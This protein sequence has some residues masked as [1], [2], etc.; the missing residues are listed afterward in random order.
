MD[1]AK[2]ATMRAPASGGNGI[3]RGVFFDWTD[4]ELTLQPRP[5][6]FPVL[7][8][9]T[10]GI[11]L[12]ASF[13]VVGVWDPAARKV[14]T[15]SNGLSGKMTPSFVAFKESERLVGAD[16]MCAITP[17]EENVFYDMK[18]LIGRKFTDPT[19]Q[20]NLERWPFQVLEG[21]QGSPV[22]EATFKG[23]TK[24]F[25]PEH[26][27]AM[28][29]SEMKDIAETRLGCK[30]KN[31]VITVP[32]SFNYLQRQCTKEAG[33]IAGLNVIGILSEPAAAAIA[34]G[35]NKEEL[36]GTRLLVFDLG[37][38]TLNVSLLLV[39]EGV[40][41]LPKRD[42]NRPRVQFEVLA[43]AGDTHLG[44]ANFTN[45]MADKCKEVFEERQLQAGNRVNLLL[46]PRA[47]KT[48]WNHCENAKRD[49]CENGVARIRIDKLQDSA[50][51]FTFTSEMF[52]ELCSKE[53]KKCK[54]TVEGVIEQAELKI[55]AIQN[56]LLVG[57]STRVPMI[58]GML[59]EM[60]GR[61]KIRDDLSPDEAVAY[62][63]T[64]VGA[65]LSLDKPDELRGFSLVDVMAL[66]LSVKVHGQM[67]PL[68]GK[69]TKVP[70]SKTQTFGAHKD[71]QESVLIEIYS[72]ALSSSAD[73]EKLGELKLPIDPPMLASDV[74]MEVTF[75]IDGDG[76]L[77]VQALGNF[78]NGR[79]RL[80]LQVVLSR[81]SN[82]EIDKMCAD[83][84]QYRAE[85]AARAHLVFAKV[86]L[87]RTCRRVTSFIHYDGARL[88]I[89]SPSA[90]LLL[91]VVNETLALLDGDAFATA[92]AVEV[93]EKMISNIFTS[94]GGPASNDNGVGES[95]GVDGFRGF[96][97][98]D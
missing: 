10:I 81:L 36:L 90:E 96:D 84:E 12:G 45:L 75:K 8:R 50:F 46:R 3:A 83:L 59:V 89:N 20:A 48:L 5:P 86:R 53:F 73:N 97:E 2:R 17:N 69:N 62:G 68:I 52:A 42:I 11:D 44:G 65:S 35:L 64:V 32:A 74:K 43:T 9:E 95:T 87:E 93:K 26:L 6:A 40:E 98:L 7:A 54:E 29:L 38:G 91:S 51:T 55:D 27:T 18:R 14:A 1:R 19:V 85:D 57:G 23:E 67:I 80:D 56:V 39:K 82:E 24:K 13:S 58:K 71:F 37:G 66:P 47:L 79:A 16:A 31:A 22:L 78:K 70:C 4:C 88:V 34:Y 15:V 61:D 21:D 94:M 28:I 76:I 92:V 33:W 30:V 41:D 72:G 63:A 77:S 60:F 25:K 49:L